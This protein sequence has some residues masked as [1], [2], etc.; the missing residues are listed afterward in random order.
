MSS[1]VDG[2]GGPESPAVAAASPR[3]PVMDDEMPRAVSAAASEPSEQSLPPRGGTVVSG[4][5]ATV[6]EAARDAVEEV[7]RRVTAHLRA[8]GVEAETA[9]IPD[10]LIC[11]GLL[12]DTRPTFRGQ[13]VHGVTVERQ[14]RDLGGV[15]ATMYRV[16]MEYAISEALLSEAETAVRRSRRQE[17]GVWWANVTVAVLLVCG[18]V[19]AAL[20]L[21]VQRSCHETD[22]KGG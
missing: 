18:G 12:A 2:N 6:P 3:R 16:R 1:A 13:V 7:K 14:Q 15:E 22:G 11:D 9:A 20:G 19:F 4:W 8:R 10:E 21:A 17:D 5:Y